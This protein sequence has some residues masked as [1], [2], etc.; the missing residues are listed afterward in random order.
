MEIQ[1]NGELNFSNII[2]AVALALT[3]LQ[4]A[5][6]FI[7]SRLASSREQ[8]SAI[9]AWLKEANAPDPGPIDR[10]FVPQGGMTAVI[11]NNSGDLIYNVIATVVLFYGAGPKRGSG[12]NDST[13]RFVYPTVPPGRHEQPIGHIDT[14]M[15]RALAVEVAFTDRKGAS[16]VRTG[17]G[18]LKRLWFR[19]SA[20]EYYGIGYP[21][22]WTK[23]Y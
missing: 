18:E 5:T 3:L 7:K 22:P 16:W 6:S 13:Q 1:F 21:P 10:R 2:A 14:S 12:A 17:S 8:A 15:N 9:S 4:L 23:R 20:L 19:K 11:S